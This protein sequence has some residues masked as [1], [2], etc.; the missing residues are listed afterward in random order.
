MLESALVHTLSRTVQDI[1][2]NAETPS[3]GLPKGACCNGFCWPLHPKQGEPNT[4]T[5]KCLTQPSTPSIHISATKATKNFQAKRHRQVV[6][7]SLTLTFGFQ[8]GTGHLRLAQARRIG[9]VAK[10]T[11]EDVAAKAIRVGSV[12]PQ[13]VTSRAL[14]VATGWLLYAE[15]TLPRQG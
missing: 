8:E 6:E 14:L 4:T 12:S 10:Q 9:E 11:L 1:P 13:A 7:R 2:V 15:R 3:G 5:K